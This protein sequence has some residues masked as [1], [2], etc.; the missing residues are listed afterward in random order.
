MSNNIFPFVTT[1]VG[2]PTIL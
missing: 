1:L 2:G